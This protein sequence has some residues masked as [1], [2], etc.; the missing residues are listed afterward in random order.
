LVGLNDAL[1]GIVAERQVKF[2]DEAASAK[3]G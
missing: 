3:A 1:G 2:L